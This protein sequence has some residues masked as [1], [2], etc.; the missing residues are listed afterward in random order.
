[1]QLASSP[2]T[3]VERTGSNFQSSV[4][5]ILSASLRET[6]DSRK[7]QLAWQTSCPKTFPQP[8]NLDRVERAWGHCSLSTDWLKA[9]G[10]VAAGIGSSRAFL[11]NG[12]TLLLYVQ[13]C[14]TDEGLWCMA[15]INLFALGNQFHV[16]RCEFA[17][18]QQSESNSQHLWDA[19]PFF[20][21]V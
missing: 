1:M 21:H 11:I 18:F 17:L 8:P 9:G 12:C 6:F 13:C 20:E 7:S 15:D 3:A 19:L 16:I 10:S 5:N 14:G 4:A 2:V